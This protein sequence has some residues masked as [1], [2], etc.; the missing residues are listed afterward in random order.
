MMRKTWNS[1]TYGAGAVQDI[2]PG[3]YSAPLLAITHFGLPRE[4]EGGGTT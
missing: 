2:K 3:Y 1:N 4:E